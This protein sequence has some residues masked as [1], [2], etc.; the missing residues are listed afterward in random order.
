MAPRSRGH[1]DKLR[2]APR[3]GC[4]SMDPK[5]IVIAVPMPRNSTSFSIRLSLRFNC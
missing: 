1:R 5:R 4:Q 2:S 3:T